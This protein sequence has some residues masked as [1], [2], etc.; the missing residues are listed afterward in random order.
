VNSKFQKQYSHSLDHECFPKGG[1]VEG[2]EA[3][4]RWG[5]VRGSKVIGGITSKVIMGPFFSLVHGVSGFA[6]PHAPA[7]IASL[8]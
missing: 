1:P 5:L 7:M 4:G 2:D 6:A 3:F 8:P